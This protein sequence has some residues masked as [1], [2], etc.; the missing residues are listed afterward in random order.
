MSYKNFHSAIVSFRKMY[1]GD[2]KQWVIYQNIAFAERE[3]TFG[4]CEKYFNNLIRSLVEKRASREQVTDLLLL[5]GA[6]FSRTLNTL[7]QWDAGVQN[8]TDLHVEHYWDYLA[9]NLEQP[10]NLHDMK[11]LLHTTTW[12]TIRSAYPSIADGRAFAKHYV[13]RCIFIA[14]RYT[15][16]LTLALWRG[17]SLREE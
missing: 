8:P 12:G 1:R 5:S 16:N 11:Q 14:E 4:Q 17:R 10:E 2:A 7:N 3:K 9:E 15:R 6:M 13:K